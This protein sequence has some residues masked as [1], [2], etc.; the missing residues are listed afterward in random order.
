M[1]TRNLEEAIDAVSKVYCPHTVEVVGP[2]GD[3]DALLEVAHPTLQPLVSLSYSV[4][5]KIDALN[6]SRLFL[7][8]HCARGAAATTQGRHSA[9]WSQGQT[10]PFSAG[11][12][13]RLWFD[14]AFLQRS[15]RLDIDKLEAQCARWL[16]HPL[17]EPLR[18]ALRPFS[19]DLEEIWRRT[20]S[21]LWSSEERGLPLGPAAK[22]AFDEYL[23]TLLLHHHPHNYSNEMA[24]DASAPVP[25]VV[26]RAE[27]FMADSADTPIT[28]S[29]V[30]AHLGVSL[31][32]LQAGFRQWRNA[33]PNA[34]LRR[35]R[36]RLVRDELL[37]SD[38]DASVTTI[39][40]RHGFMH[41]GRFSAQYRG[42]FGE[43]PSATL[44]RGRASIS[45]Q[46]MRA[47]R[48]SR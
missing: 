40:M 23:L 39:A 32:S 10:I 4:P 21:Y 38:K 8:M 25:G 33:T 6:F 44:R 48:R 41:L 5:V 15:L 37:R 9:E 31:R 28:V 16:G 46:R 30:A 24:E 29:D 3:I 7:M 26:R 2:V 18:F 17:E 19:D 45:S 34:Y 13:T 35:V 22:S 20:L 11:F 47:V 36:L 14:R 12:D 27:H 43:G 1:R 42:E